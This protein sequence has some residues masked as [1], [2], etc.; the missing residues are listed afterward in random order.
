MAGFSLNA[1]F[2]PTGFR[3]LNLIGSTFSIKEKIKN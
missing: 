2:H 1:L 3:Q